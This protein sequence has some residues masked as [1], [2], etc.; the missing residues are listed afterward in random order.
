MFSLG[1]YGV[2]HE[3]RMHLLKTSTFAALLLSCLAASSPAFGFYQQPLAI[4][5]AG[6][7]Q[8]E[9]GPFV[10]PGFAFYPGEYANFSFQIAG[11]RVPETKHIQLEYV[12]EMVDAKGVALVPPETGKVDTQVNPEDK[13][14]LPKVRASFLIPSFLIPGEFRIRALVKDLLAKQETSKEFSFRIEGRRIEPAAALTIQNFRFFRSENDKEALEVRSYRA[15]DEIWAR[16]DIVGFKTGAKNLVNVEYG[17]TVLRPNGQ[18]LFS[19][20]K[21]ANEKKESFYPMPFVPGTLSVK[22]S[23]DVPKGAYTLLVTVRDVVGGQTYETRESFQ[24][25]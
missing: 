20:P 14:W 3:K 22:L 23:S 6:V 13:D 11:Y 15:G 10:Q 16:F 25:E 21:A 5:Q 7:Q 2:V 4:V 9:D 19:D 18:A 8:T 12:V 24:I 1:L 17:L